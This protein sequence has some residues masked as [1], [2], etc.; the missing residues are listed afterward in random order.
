MAALVVAS[1]LLD[2]VAVGAAVDSDVAAS[3]RSSGPFL[4]EQPAL[5]LKVAVVEDL[6]GEDPFS[7]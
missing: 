4:L 2:T 3:A 5:M 1:I 7:C 6:V